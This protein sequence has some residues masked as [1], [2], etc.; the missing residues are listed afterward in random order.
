MDVQLPSA[1]L[2]QGGLTA[3]RQVETQDGGGAGAGRDTSQLLPWAQGRDLWTSWGRALSDPLFL[4]RDLGHLKEK[5]CSKLLNN[6]NANKNSK[7][8]T[9]W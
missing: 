7:D 3:Q 8:S 5:T 1:H 6:G 4:R 2:D 9:V